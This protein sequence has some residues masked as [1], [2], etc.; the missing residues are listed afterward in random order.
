MD[1]I[2]FAKGKAS[3]GAV[4]IEVVPMT[5]DY[6]AFWHQA[7]QPFTE[8]AAV[9]R[10]D[11]RWHWGL[12][13]H[14]ARF[15]PRARCYCV[16]TPAPS[17]DSVPAGM[18]LVIGDYP[19]LRSRRYK[20]TFLWF[21]AAAPD[22]AMTALG[23]TDPPSLGRAL[24]DTSIVDSY[25]S[26]HDGRI[27]LHAAPSG[28]VRL[29]DFYKNACNLLNLPRFL[30]LPLSAASV[31]QTL[32]NLPVA[33]DGRFFYTDNACATSFINHWSHWR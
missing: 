6:A 11:R 26:G 5:A 2:S 23:I 7:I 21:L 4:P 28:G 18:L 27:G 10:A 13:F 30:V 8:T 12:L 14:A 9:P 22:S 19:W 16:T 29:F 20:S 15:L 25:R 24:V 3:K 31:Q 32:A 1:F 17:G 33:N